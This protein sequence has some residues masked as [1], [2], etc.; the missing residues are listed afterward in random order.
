MR[1]IGAREVKK[2]PTLRGRTIINLFF[3]PST[4]TRRASRSPASGSPQT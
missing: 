1:E 3:E 2:V 4:R